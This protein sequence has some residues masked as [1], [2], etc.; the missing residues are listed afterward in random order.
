MKGN[1]KKLLNVSE[2]FEKN[3]EKQDVRKF[4]YDEETDRQTD[5]QADNLTGSQADRRTDRRTDRQNGIQAD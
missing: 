5:W 4:N 2:V 3:G 1:K